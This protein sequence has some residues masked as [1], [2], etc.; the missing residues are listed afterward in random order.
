MCAWYTHACADK[1]VFL[2]L[3]F[4]SPYPVWRN[5][6]PNMQAFA[7][8]GIKGIYAEGD[9][10]NLYGDLQELSMYMN[11]MANA[12]IAITTMTSSCAMT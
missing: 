11:S 1:A 8:A 12:T 6:I 2:D 4:L 3:G 7:R 9:M 5:Q 10:T